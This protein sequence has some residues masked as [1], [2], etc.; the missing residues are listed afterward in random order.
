MRDALLITFILILIFVV[1]G[2]IYNILAPYLVKLGVRE[3]SVAL[4]NDGGLFRSLDFG[5]TWEHIPES[6]DLARS[7]VYE[8]HFSPDNSNVIYVA[9]SSGLYKSDDSGDKWERVTLGSLSSVL[10]FAQ[11]P[12]NSLRMYVAGDSDSGSHI[13][14]TRQEDFYEVYS[15]IDD[16]I[17]GIWVDTFDAVTV[18]A[19][20][21]KGFFLESKDFGES[22]RV[23]REF[24]ASIRGLKI[25][26]DVMYVIVGDDTLFRSSNRGI[27]WV[28]ITP[29]VS[30]IRQITVSPHNENVLYLTTSDGLFRSQNRGDS[31]S[32]IDILAEDSSELSAVALDAQKPGV[33]Y[34]GIGNQVH[35]TNDSGATWQIKTMDTLRNINIIRV[36]PDTSNTIFVGVSS[37]L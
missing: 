21:R 25:L 17:V 5:R 11:D 12:N 4:R 29:R 3:E 37:G 18:Y 22:W 7:D 27:S 34:I 30:G 10:S 24:G 15:N 20:T 36:K 13:F 33:I 31:F 28:N 23:N 26:E 8:L 14:K 32:K 19:G 35:K 1:I 2:V 9:S 6:G 16:E